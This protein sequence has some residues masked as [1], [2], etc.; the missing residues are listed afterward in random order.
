MVARSV[1][2][3]AALGL[4]QGAFANGAQE[5]DIAAVRGV[6]ETYAATSTANDL[7]GWMAVWDEEGIRMAPGAPAIAGK[8]KIREAMASIIKD[9]KQ[10]V[11]LDIQEVRV[12]GDIGYVR[13]DGVVEISWKPG[14]PLTVLSDGK[15]LSVC[16]RQA[17]GS[18]KL[19]RDI[20]NDNVPAQAP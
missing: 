14:D 20:F 2:M 7:E 8:E 16:R 1:L 10:K 12:S 4:G 19:Y 11:T 9:Y 15:F 6:L 3:L 18:W 17:D 5:K 13:G